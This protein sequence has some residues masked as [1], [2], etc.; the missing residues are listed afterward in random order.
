MQ[1]LFYLPTTAP[2]EERCAAR[3]PC[4]HK[5]RCLRFRAAQVPGTPLA[6]HSIDHTLGACCGKFL[7]LP[8][9]HTAP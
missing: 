8:D 3:E 6:D 5:V 1:R 4:E 2:P 7:A 9:D